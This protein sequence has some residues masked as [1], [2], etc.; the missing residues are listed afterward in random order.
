[1]P[2]TTGTEL[3]TITTQAGMEEKSAHALIA[4]F[5]PLKTR[6]DDACA[7][8]LLVAVKD[9][10]DTKGMEHAKAAQK[11]VREIRLEVE[12]TRK[13]FKENALRT[14]QAIDKIAGLF[15]DQIEPVEARLKELA[16]FAKRAEQARKEKIA[17]ERAEK[18]RAVEVDPAIY[19]LAVMEEA[20]FESLLEGSTLAFEKRK[21]I[22]AEQARAKLAAEQAQAKALQEQKAEN[23]RLRK[24]QADKDAAAKKERDAIAEQA[25]KAKDAADAVV[26]TERL[27]REKAENELKQ[28][29]AEEQ[30]KIDD[31]AKAAARAAAA[32]DQEKLMALALLIRQIQ[33]PAMAT[34]AADEMTI[35]IRSWIG[36]LADRI[37]KDAKTL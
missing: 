32:P 26:R 12:A 16:E 10:S 1:M 29:R 34:A 28:K 24:E 33:V 20:A 31:E 23:D 36:L 22:T 7:D 15:T 5:L 25:R 35:K 6:L 37:E 27:A 14:G 13:K 18:L 8:A 4:A 11:T 2:V 9:E 3:A 17:T 21:Q 19:P 30:Q